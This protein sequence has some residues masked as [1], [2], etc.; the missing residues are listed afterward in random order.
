MIGTGQ[1]AWLQGVRY[2]ILLDSIVND[3]VAGEIEHAV[4]AAWD[5]EHPQVILLEGQGSLLNPAYPGGFELLAAGRPRAVLLQHA[6]ARV[7]HDGFPGFPIGPLERHIRLIEELSGRP[8]VAVTLN[9]EGLA[10]EE[11]AKTAGELEQAVGR[12]VVDVLRD[13]PERVIA[14]LLRRFPELA[15][16]AAERGTHA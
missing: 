1:T 16:A 6:P 8:V 9:H 4:L 5:A 15:P 3:F 14:E 10:P 12:P 7:D 11:I 2:G 13:G